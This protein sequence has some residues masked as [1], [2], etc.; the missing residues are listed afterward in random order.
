MMKG[1]PVFEVACL[2]GNPLLPDSLRMVAASSAA[3]TVI[4]SDTSRHGPGSF[5]MLSA[6]CKVSKLS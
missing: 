5:R 6:P 2:Q 3:A 1:L 4:V